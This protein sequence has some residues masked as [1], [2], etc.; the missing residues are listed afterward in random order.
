MIGKKIIYT[1]VMIAMF[2]GSKGQGIYCAERNDTINRIDIRGKKQGMWV[3]YLT[4][5]RERMS[6]RYEDDSLV[7]KRV[8]TIDSS[9]FLHRYPVVE[10]RE[11][12]EVY[13]FGSEEKGWFDYK[14]GEITLLSGRSAE[15][16]DSTIKFL[17]GIPPVYEFG[18]EN[19]SDKIED[20]VYPLRKSNKGNKAVVEMLVDRNGMLTSVSIRLTKPNK[21]LEEQLKQILWGFKRWQPAFDTWHNQLYKKQLVLTF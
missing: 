18:R 11:P 5:G 1:F 6:C 20:L 17:M 3:Y 4:D 7:G 21:K 14:T 9:I 16:L 13:K 8:Y 10:G 19:L 12:F 2:L 15:S